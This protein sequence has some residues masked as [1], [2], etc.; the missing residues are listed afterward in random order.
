MLVRTYLLAILVLFAFQLNG[1]TIIHTEKGGYLSDLRSNEQHSD[2]GRQELK[3]FVIS[4]GYEQELSEEDVSTEKSSNLYGMPVKK[5]Y[6]SFVQNDHYYYAISQFFDQNTSN[7][8]LEDYSCRYRTYDTH[9]GTDYFAFPFYWYQYENE[10]FEVVAAQDGFVKGVSDTVEDACNINSEFGNWV[11]IDHGGFQTLYA[12]LQKGSITVEYDQFVSK[13][14]IIGLVGYSGNSTKP[15]LH[16][17]TYSR[18]FNDSIHDPYYPGSEDCEA[19]YSLYRMERNGYDEYGRT[20]I[21]SI[22]SHN[23]EPRWKTE[24]TDP[25]EEPYFENNF[26]VGETAHF[27]TAVRD[28]YAE[29]TLVTELIKPDGNFAAQWRHDLAEITDNPNAELEVAVYARNEFLIPADAPMGNWTLQSYLLDANGS[30]IIPQPEGILSHTIIV[31]GTSDNSE[32]LSENFK[33]YPQ[34]ANEKLYVE[35]SQQLISEGKSFTLELT[36]ITGKTCLEIDSKH[37]MSR[38]F[39]NISTLQ[40]GLYFMRYKDQYGYSTGCKKIIIQ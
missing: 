36:D 13:E 31:D 12:H 14:E 16:F 4:L 40:S 8:Y 34:P 33:V 20:A 29:Q 22:T 30:P 2:N 15:H 23:Q 39:I 25:T 32:F 26:K 19:P 37:L 35:L 27:I 38:S 1:Q 3:D 7:G 24:C 10:L 28:M 6:E 18:F 11:L 17:E 21:L 5:S 9:S